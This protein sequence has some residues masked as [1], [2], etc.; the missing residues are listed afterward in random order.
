MSDDIKLDALYQAWTIIA[1]V[2]GGDWSQQSD[3]WQEAAKRWRDEVFHP[4]LGGSVSP[5]PPDAV[6]A[7]FVPGSGAE[8]PAVRPERFGEMMEAVREYDQRRH[9]P[10]AENLAGY[11]NWPE[12]LDSQFADS[13]TVRPERCPTCG[14]DNPRVLRFGRAFVDPPCDNPWHFVPSPERTER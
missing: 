12:V 9:E 3:E 2:S 5:P 6:I 14:S 1:N 4:L 10:P 11:P 8:P 13:G 7:A